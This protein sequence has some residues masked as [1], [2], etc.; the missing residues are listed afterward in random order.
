MRIRKS[1]K[2]R[3]HNSQN[4]K[5]QKDK[6]RSTK[7]KHRTKDRVRRTPLKPSCPLTE[8]MWQCTC[9][10][11]VSKIPHSQITGRAALRSD[12]LMPCCPSFYFKHDFIL[13]IHVTGFPVIFSAYSLLKNHPSLSPAAPLKTK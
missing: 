1:K 10:T 11:R 5:E 9:F 3:Q 8:M 13:L 2:E 4:E 6:Q 12:T 7:P